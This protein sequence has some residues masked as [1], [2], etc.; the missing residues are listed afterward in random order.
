MLN[1][2]GNGLNALNLTLEQKAARQDTLV[3]YYR[4]KSTFYQMMDQKLQ[5]T[6]VKHTVWHLAMML[7]LLETNPQ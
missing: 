1:Q 3:F 5:L 7:G 4:G 2:V 6:P